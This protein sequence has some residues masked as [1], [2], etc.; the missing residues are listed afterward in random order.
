MSGTVRAVTL[1]CVLLLG[2]IAALEAAF[3]PQDLLG[4]WPWALGVGLPLAIL[5]LAALFAIRGYVVEPGSLRVRRLLWDTVVPLDGLR[6]A[7]A[8]PDAMSGSWRLFG[9]GGL[10]VLAGLYRNRRLGTYRVLATDPRR[11]VVLEF[12]RRPLVVTPEAPAAFLAQLARCAPWASIAP[13]PG[14]L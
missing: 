14:D 2:G 4:G 8:A 12:D 7:W 3:L 11:A 1:G 13:S 10:F 5:L 9:N 6:R